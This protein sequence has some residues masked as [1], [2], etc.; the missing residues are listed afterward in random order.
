MTATVRHRGFTLVELVLV[1]AIIGVLAAIAI[2]RLSRGSAGAAVA[3]TREDLAL[4]QRQIEL[5]AA[6]HGG[7]YPAYRSD[8][9]NAAHTEGAF[10]RQM[11]GYS[12]RLGEISVTQSPA[13]PF[14]P[15][16]EGIP[17]LKAGPQAGN[18][19]VLVI[20]GNTE[21]S[22]Q[23]SGGYGWLYNDTTGRIVANLPDLLDAGAIGGEDVFAPVGG[24]DSDT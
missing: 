16:L 4:L 13:Y 20:T 14:G 8:G 10:L 9:A 7:V 12:N 2:P 15:Y 23:K 1:I 21:F 5:Y 17:P 19:G 11:L 22:Y 6:E 3:A 18:T 24:E